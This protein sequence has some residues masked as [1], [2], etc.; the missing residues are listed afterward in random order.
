[1]NGQLIS[2]QDEQTMLGYWVNI[3]QSSLLYSERAG[4]INQQV[5]II[6]LFSKQ[7]VVRHRID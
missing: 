1:M 7:T 6:K 5:F 2:L 3:E 4:L